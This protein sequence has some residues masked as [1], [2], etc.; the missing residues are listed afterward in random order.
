MKKRDYLDY[1]AF[2]YSK[3]KLKK[4]FKFTDFDSIYDF[5]RSYVGR[6]YY[7]RISLN[8]F[9]EE[10][11]A[12]ADYIKAAEPKVVV[13]IGTKK[14]GSFFIWARYLKPRHLISIDLPGGIHGGGFPKQKIPFMKFFVSDDKHAK[15]SIILGDSHQTETLEKLKSVLKGEKIDFLFI[16]GDHRYEGVKSDFEMYKPLVKPGGLIGFHDIVDTE[17]HHNLNC[18]V[19]KL[20]NEIKGDYEYIEFIQNHTQNK[21]GIGVLKV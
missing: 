17:Y 11:R 15:V 2:Q 7:D 12:F 16:D 6:G 13:E 3:I 1:F 9:K 21:Y 20:W 10:F 14:G 4:S 19:D 8:Q 5:A 18:Y